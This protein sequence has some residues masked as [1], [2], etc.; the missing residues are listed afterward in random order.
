Y[1]SLALPRFYQE[2]TFAP[3]WIDDRGVTT[4]AEDL[5]EALRG[6]YQEGLIP[7]DYHLEGIATRLDKART[8][9][10][11]GPDLYVDLELLLTD[12]F[13]VYASHLLSGRVNPETLDPEWIATRREGD[14]AQVLEKALQGAGIKEELPSLLPMGPGYRRLKTALAHYRRISDQG[15][16][17]TVSPGPKLELGSID[18]R[19]QELRRRLAAENLLADGMTADPEAFDATLRDAVLD[20]QELRG[21]DVDGIV[22]QKTIGALNIPVE[23]TV[24][25]IL[26]N[27]ERWRWLPQDLGTRY[28]LV[29]VAD[30]HLFVVQNADTILTM[31]VVVGKDQR[32]TPVFSAMMTYL[33]M[34]PYWNVPPGIASKDILPKVQKDPGFLAAQKIR[35]YSGWGADAREVDP[36][37]VRWAGMSAQRLPYRFRQDPGPQNALGL[38]KF[39]FPNKFDVYLHDTPAKGLFAKAERAFSSGCIRIEKPVELAHYLLSDDPQWTPEQI[40]KVEQEGRERTVSLPHP[41]RVHLLYWTAWVDRANRCH[42]RRDIYDRDRLLL[43]ALREPPPVQ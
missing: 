14:L 25:K 39:M 3:A 41:I 43:E 37:T 15:G 29:N 11:A 36:S 4:A 5:L 40:V 1:A 26:L 13:L 23:R 19:V 24:E 35:V 34:S 9:G 12:G 6:A 17:P 38:V 21:L 7:E 42:L 33:V 10:G 27:L 18:G 30:F 2:R 22:G 28:L 31:K 20:F 32:R 8:P 16:W